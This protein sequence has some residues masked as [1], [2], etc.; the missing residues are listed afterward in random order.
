MVL[1]LVCWWGLLP[2]LG[3]LL[4]AVVLVGRVLLCWALVRLLAVGRALVLGSGGVLVSSLG[5][6]GGEG[7][8]G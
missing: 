3:L 2:R 4:L 1:L 6:L 8:P 5:G 7:V